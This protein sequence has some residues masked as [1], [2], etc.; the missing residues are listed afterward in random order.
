M[1]T[2]SDRGAPEKG[3]LAF[4]TTR[5]V[6]ITM[7]VL[8]MVMFGAVSL[9]KLPLDL[10][11]E[12]SYPTLTIRTA[13]PGAAPEDIEERISEKVQESLSTLDDLVRSTSISRAGVSDVLLEFDWGTRMTF[14]VQDVREKL[15][16]VFLP[17]TAERPLILRY[18][19]NLDPIL[20]IGMRV[21]GGEVAGTE[22]ERERQ[23]IQ[24][25]WLAENRV[26]R[27]LESMEG[28][29]AVQLRGGLEEE[30][31]ISVDP[32]RLAANKLDPAEL[33][34]RLAAE[35]INASGGSLLE[36]T[37]EYL[38]RTVNQFRSIEEI[39]DLPVATRG[40]STIR[41]RHVAKVSRTHEKREV[42]SRIGGAESVE[43]AIYREAGANIVQLAQGVKDIVFGTEKQQLKAAELKA[44]DRKPRF[45]ERGEVEF[46][47]WRLREEAQ[48]ELLSD[49]SIFIRDAVADVKNAA[50]MG[51]FLAIAVIWAFLR[52]FSATL[53]IGISIPIS[54]LVTFAPMFLAGVSLNIMSLGGLALGVG[55]L[56][57]NAIVVLESIARCREEGDPLDRAAIRGVTEVAG[58]VI[59]ST[60]TTV[61]VFAPIVFVTGIAGQI[62]G[63]QALAVVASLAVSLIVAV[64]FIPMLASRPWLAIEEEKAT[65]AEGE[66]KKKTLADRPPLPWHGL[67]WSVE[68]FAENLLLIGGRCAIFLAGLLFSLLALVV[69]GIGKLFRL[70]TWPFSKIFDLGYGAIESVYPRIL[71]IALR[72]RILIVLLAGVLLY[73]T[74]Q[75]V[76]HLGVELLP[77]IH[78]GEFTAF[79][80]LDAGSPLVLTD[81]VMGELDSEV[82]RLAGV[83]S[84][85]LACG[86]ESDTLTREIE[87]S[88]TARLTVRMDDVGRSAER[89]ES[90]ADNVRALL[91][92]HPAVQ[93]VDISRPTPFALASPIAV[94]VL[95]FD[96]AAIEAV[97]EEVRQRLEALDVLSDVRSS[98]RPGFPEARVTFNR[99]KTLELGLDL[100][101]VSQLV[102]DQVLGNVSTRFREGEERIAVRV[103]ADA[104][105]LSTI[106]A[107]MELP[108]NPSADSPVPLRSVASVEIVQGPAE[109]RRIGNT[110]A[111]V[112]SATAGDLDLGGASARIE[113]A[114]ADLV[115]PADITVALGGQKREMDEAQSSLNFALILAVFLV[116]VVMAS[117][118]E[119]LIQPMVILLTVPLAGVGV[120][121]G[122]E[123]LDVPLSVVVFMGLIML[124]GI[125]VNNAIVLVDRIN[126][127]RADGHAV[128]E[129]ILE[130]GLARLRPILM[131]TLTTILGLLPLTGW[132][133][134]IPY[135]G[136]FG[137]GEGAEIRAPMAITV[138]LGLATSTLLT[139]I[140][141]PT[142]YSLVSRSAPRSAPKTHA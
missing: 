36:G 119:S 52:R 86:V 89:E 73:A 59:A 66:S 128:D 44:Q 78:Q 136:A 109:I 85:A 134:G 95:G 28:I 19:P 57:D 93:Q 20:R 118:F 53:I 125:V 55:M 82:R 131:T 48:L 24:L 76:S 51:A 41:L 32:Q 33:S 5:P 111:V 124:A 91:S 115:I 35:N 8:A 127:R 65:A 99:E 3:V 25:R 137:A 18:D 49:Q 110:R 39:E 10:L 107:V 129:A 122:L 114:L 38:V 74:S 84:T 94:E 11:P 92:S 58:A 30:I 34:R 135:L 62:F 7:L 15:D 63:D 64:L 103:I 14:A 29:A 121:F 139:L 98:V 50:I 45:D 54:I 108:V 17:Q 16:G 130:A 43:I 4:V 120:I 90:L 68:F 72:V 1:K 126:Q 13:W 102:R 101:S 23:L 116:Y 67:T 138:I 87:G 106:D 6:A 70:V 142:A 104:E 46:L 2:Q 96:L 22:E 123:L 26:K 61:S 12:I 77:E 37:N 21:P 31:W 100:A 105:V 80:R 40:S 42:V 9:S 83:A 133:S 117:Q 97:G 47:S 113:E 132:L 141:I 71:K 79:V 69:V 140:V 60:L 88:H 112:V 81:E 56:V 27:E 75:R